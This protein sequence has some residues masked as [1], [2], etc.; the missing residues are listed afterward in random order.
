MRGRSRCRRRR[1]SR[2]VDRLRLGPVRVHRHRLDRSMTRVPGVQGRGRQ[3]DLPRARR[4]LL[5]GIEGPDRRRALEDDPRRES[6]DRRR[7]L[8]LRDQAAPG[9]IDGASPVGLPAPT[10][11]NA[12][13]ATTRAVPKIHTRVIDA[14]RTI[15]PGGGLAIRFDLQVRR[16]ELPR[17]D[18]DSA[19]EDR[20]EHRRRQPAGE[21]VLLARVVRAEQRVRPDPRLGE[22]PE[23]RPRRDR[24]P[25][26]P[27]TPGAPR[28]SRTGRARRRPAPTRAAP[29]RGPGTARRCR[30]PRSSACWPAARSGRPPRC[31]RRSASARRR[32]AG[33]TADRPA[34]PRTAAPTGSPRSR[35]R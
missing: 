33:S 32:R 16:R 25:Q 29:A 5:R 28:P 7:G 27:R 13:I 2:D 8:G 30:A 10:Q 4:V 15:Q 11:P 23:P 19:A 17:R 21:R 3:F 18:V 26:L 24:V 9:R 20:V 6:I 31:T 35:R 34:P 12:T 22:M 14:I 1:S